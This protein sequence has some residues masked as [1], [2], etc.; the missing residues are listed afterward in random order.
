MT[1]A[2][3][4]DLHHAFAIRSRG[5][6]A[7][8]IRVIQANLEDDTLEQAEVTGAGA[9]IQSFRSVSEHGPWEDILL[10]EFSCRSCSARFQLFAD[11]YHGRGGHWHPVERS[12]DE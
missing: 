2:S 9:S 1:C 12:D 3:C 4:Q 11:T 8:A 7:R 6:L 5:E 10:Y